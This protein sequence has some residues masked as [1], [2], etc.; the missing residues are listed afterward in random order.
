MKM[1]IFSK[2]TIVPVLL[3][4]SAFYLAACSTTAPSNGGS[5]EEALEPLKASGFIEAEE[6]SVVSEV[7]GLVDQ[8]L[9]DE[10]DTVEAGQTLIILNDALLQADRVE[11]AAAVAIAEA[12]LADLKTGASE[13]ELEAAQ[14]AIDEAQAR[15]DGTERASGQAWGAAGDPQGVDVQLASVRTEA[16]LAQRQLE[17]LQVQLKEAEIVYDWLSNWADPSDPI[18]IEFKGYE[19]EMLKAQVRAAEIRH[20]GALEKIQ[21][22]EQQ[23]ERPLSA[24]AQARSISSQIPI[25]EHQLEL[26]QARYDLLENGPLTEEIAILEAQVDLARAGVALI[27]AQIARLTLIA[28]IDGVVTTRAIHTGETATAGISLLT[29]SNLNVLKLVVYIPENQ[30]GQVQLGEPVDLMVD[31]YPNETFTGEI[32]FIARE[33]EFTPRNVQTEE[34]RVN[35]VFAVEIRIDNE[36]G[37]LKPGM[38]ADVVIETNS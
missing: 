18:A 37:K 36:E 3:S 21:L 14:A 29:I 28:P 13:E 5:S 6:V 4:L 31:A 20:Q 12:S 7:S 24:I 1:I 33:A 30:I 32:T 17:L 8:V 26:A 15:I 23:Q 22:L 11:A 27:D 38:P 10:G 9:A 34:E 35:L 16:D 25:Y 19:V 2:R